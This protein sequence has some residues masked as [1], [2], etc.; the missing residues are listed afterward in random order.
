MFKKF[1]KKKENPISA[2]I[3]W[4]INESIL[5]FDTGDSFMHYFDSNTEIDK[6]NP[7]WQNQGLFF[8][9]DKESFE[10]K[11]LP[12]DFLKFERK[13]FLLNKIPDYI[14][15][16]AGKAM[17]WFGKP[18]GGDKYFFKYEDNPITIEEAEKLNV[19]SYF[20]YTDINEQNLSILKDRDNYIFQLDRIVEYKNKEF[21]YQNSKTSLSNLYHKGFLKVLKIK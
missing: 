10:K 2:K 15:I 5:T 13:T 17:P 4:C 12:D 8:W 1:F 20:D 18:G 3:D 19:I 9:K 16:A 14:E 7:A 21:Y 6:N 11:S